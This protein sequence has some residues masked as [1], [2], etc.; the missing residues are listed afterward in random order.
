MAARKKR[1]AK[2]AAAPDRAV[3]RASV[4]TP[5]TPQEPKG[6]L[7]DRLRGAK[8][9]KDVIELRDHAHAHGYSAGGHLMTAIADRLSAFDKEG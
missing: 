3:A 2:K 7:W 9:R 8:S 1:T 4:T 5:E 6:Y